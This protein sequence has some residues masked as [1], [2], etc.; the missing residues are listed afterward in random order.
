MMI[1]M[2]KAVIVE[3]EKYSR[4]QLKALLNKYCRNVELIGEAG[5]AQD[6][7]KLILAS[8]PDLIF[9][10]IQMPKE[11]GFEMLASLGSYEF[12]VIFVTG[13]DQYGIQAIKCSA[14]DYLVKPVDPEELVKAVNKAEA[15]QIKG[16]LNQQLSNMHNTLVNPNKQEHHIIIP[17]E[18]DY[19]F[20]DPSKIMYIEA[21]GN[22]SKLFFVKGTPMLVSKSIGFFEDVCFDYG[23]V[24]VHQSY[25]VNKRFINR[26]NRGKFTDELLLTDDTSV[27]V[28]FRKREYVRQDL[29][30]ERE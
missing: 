5:N 25:L 12:D 2:I 6:G 29:L 3:D 16:N 27:P 13:H 23:F 26:L 4:K 17:V 20:A 19:Y 30:K 18:A 9:L 22:Y 28:S 15:K 24:R 7:A 1:S 11:S 10:D 14:L 21:S 8:K